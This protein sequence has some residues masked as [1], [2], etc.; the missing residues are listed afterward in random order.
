MPERLSVII[1]V[2]SLFALEIKLVLLHKSVC[3]AD[4]RRGGVKAFSSKQRSL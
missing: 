2:F 1:A 3:E 4:E